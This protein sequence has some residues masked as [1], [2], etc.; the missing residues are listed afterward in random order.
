MRG[1]LGDKTM[2]D[3]GLITVPSAHDFETTLGR[4]LAALA[5]KSITV[6][7]RV[8]RAAGAADVGLR[9]RPTTL[10]VFG[11]PIAGTPLMEA[12]Q[13]AGIDLPLK[14]LV[15]QDADGTVKLSYNDPH[16][17]AARHKLGDAVA[18]PVEGMSALLS[19]LAQRATG[20]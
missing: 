6:F 13:V 16:W 18:K 2:A 3:D 12:A 17:L 8:D 5:D 10:V 7:A 19:A 20:T 1:R 4:L 14:A 11:N 15:W 9:L